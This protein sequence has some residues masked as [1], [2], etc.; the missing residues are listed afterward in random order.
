MFAVF[1]AI[2]DVRIV[3]HKSGKSKGCAYVEFEEESAASAA[4]KAEDIV[5][6]GMV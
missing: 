5:L 4:L 3:T 1:G 2:R 6:L